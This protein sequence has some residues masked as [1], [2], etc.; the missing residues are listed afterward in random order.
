MTH[1]E[2]WNVDQNEWS[3]TI[4]SLN[5]W[6][7]DGTFSD[8]KAGRFKDNPTCLVHQVIKILNHIDKGRFEEIKQLDNTRFD[9]LG[10]TIQEIRYN[11]NK[12][13]RDKFVG[14]GNIHI[15]LIKK[16]LARVTNV[17]KYHTKSFEPEELVHLTE[18]Y[19]NGGCA[20]DTILK[21]LNAL[22]YKRMSEIITEYRTAYSD[23]LEKR[24]NQRYDAKRFLTEHP[25]EAERLAAVYLSPKTLE[26]I[27]NEE[28]E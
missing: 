19:V 11:I 26:N 2:L 17:Y 6:I 5:R 8:I 16:L 12:L 25:E 3:A 20:D 14:P 1:I 24:E 28:D 10:E 15:L 9:L 21:E 27:K 4:H 18:R 7:I 23:L 13:D 22:I